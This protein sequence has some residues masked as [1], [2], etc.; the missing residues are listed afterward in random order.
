MMDQLEPVIVANMPRLKN[1]A[2]RY[3]GNMP[4]AEDVVQ[5]AILTACRKIHQ[6]EGRSSLLT[7]LYIIVVRTALMRLRRGSAVFVPLSEDDGLVSAL[8]SPERVLARKRE[9]ETVRLAVTKLTPP[10]RKTLFFLL[11]TEGSLKEA[12]EVHGVSVNTVKARVIRARRHFVRHYEKL[13]GP[14]HA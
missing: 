5:D 9:A 10:E 1:L 13:T 7:W 3:M 2:Y 8:D 6:F 12:A 4:D 11:D 14:V